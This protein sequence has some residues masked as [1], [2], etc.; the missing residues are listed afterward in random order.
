MN[1]NTNLLDK[2][3]SLELLGHNYIINGN[4][5]PAPQEEIHVKTANLLKNQLIE[6]S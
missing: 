5:K 4:L 1:D 6:R 2:K 3:L